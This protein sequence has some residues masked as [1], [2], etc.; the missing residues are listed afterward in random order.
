M[1]PV[2]SPALYCTQ[3]CATSHRQHYILTSRHT[4]KRIL[5]NALTALNSTCQRH[6]ETGRDVALRNHYYTR[7]TIWELNPNLAQ[8]FVHMSFNISKNPSRESSYSFGLS[9]DFSEHSTSS[10]ILSTVLAVS[11]AMVLRSSLP[12]SISAS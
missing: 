1:C 11:G 10:N 3:R 6:T 8:W 2:T 12:R 9:S 5:T 4:T 7:L